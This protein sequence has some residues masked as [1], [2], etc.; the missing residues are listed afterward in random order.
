MWRLMIFPAL[1]VVPL[2]ADEAS[3][4]IPAPVPTLAA[5]EARE[6]S[7]NRY[8]NVRPEF[9]DAV[10]RL[11]ESN[12]LSSAEDFFRASRLAQPMMPEYKSARIQY[13]LLL[14][15]A[16]KGSSEAVKALPESWDS[17]LHS[18][19]R[20]MRFDPFAIVSS[21]PDSDAFQL[22]PAPKSIA[23]VFLHPLSAMGVAAKSPNNP[24]VQQIVDDD[25]A[26][27]AKWEKLT[28]AEFKA[29][30][31]AD[32]KRGLRTQEIIGLGGL[33][34]AKD[35]ANAS[36]VM[37]HSSNFTGYELAHELAV[38]SMLLGD[39]A[40]GRWLVAATYDRMLRSAGL[41]Q[42]FGT[43]GEFTIGNAGKPRLAITDEKGICD[44]ERLALGCPTLAAKRADF[45]AKKPE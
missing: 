6:P 14:A 27:R 12:V 43:Q 7:E 38:C 21:N 18:I 17:L 32:H 25:Q 31:A 35:F 15:A 19:G 23:D 41:D 13:E 5:L 40:Q 26:V 1:C 33:H 2:L 16:G 37:Q 20:P 8:P 4:P 45:Y 36:L 24:E 28:E 11:V 29:I 44:A 39:R 3:S 34:T 22:D 9:H 10:V 42:R 30:G